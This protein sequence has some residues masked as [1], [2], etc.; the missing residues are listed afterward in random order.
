[1]NFSN[2]FFLKEEVSLIV[3]MVFLLLF[4]LFATGKIRR[5]FHLI[6]CVALGGHLLYNL[7]PLAEAKAFGG[8]YVPR[9][10]SK[11][12][13]WAIISAIAS[14]DALSRISMQHTWSFR[15]LRSYSLPSLSI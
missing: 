4:D 5:Y 14:G 15:I 8:M 3:V 13:P 11:S 7:Q 2:L 12:R 10:Q 9:H 6:A 1:M